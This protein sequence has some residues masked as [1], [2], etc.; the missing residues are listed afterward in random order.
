MKNTK[1]DFILNISKFNTII[2]KFFDSK[3][4]WLWFNEFIV[5]YYLDNSVDKKIKR[6]DLAEK[7]WLTASW[8]TR[9]LLPMEKVWLVKK[10]V[11]S[12]DARV[13]LVSISSWWKEKLDDEYERMQMYL[14]EN[15]LEDEKILLDFSKFIKDTWSNFLWK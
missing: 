6:I 13:S 1:I 9:L 8:I 14:D 5:L 11:N 2:M 7:V 12:S 4:W 15:I 3:L 10:E